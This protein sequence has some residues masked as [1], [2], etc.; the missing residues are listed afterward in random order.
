MVTREASWSWW[1]K[2]C[3]RCRAPR[4]EAW[5]AVT[6]LCRACA[7][8]P[9]VRASASVWE[10]RVFEVRELLDGPARGGLQ[11]LAERAHWRLG[12]ATVEWATSGTIT[13]ERLGRWARGEEPVPGDA[14]LTLGWLV[15]ARDEHIAGHTAWKAWQAGE[16][17]RATL[18]PSAAAWS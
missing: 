13:G 5:M 14:E 10:R 4:A 6:G 8:S 1:L 3:L 7:V 9:E 11:R 12:A 15:A 16:A 18:A 17:P 2:G